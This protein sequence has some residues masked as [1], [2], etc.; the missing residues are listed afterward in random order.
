MRF[1]DLETNAS[2]EDVMYEIAT[3]HNLVPKKWMTIEEPTEAEIQ[4]T[5]SRMMTN[6]CYVRVVKEEHSE[7]LIGFIW[8]EIYEDH[9]MI[10]SLYV[11][12]AYRHQGIATQL[13]KDLEAWCLENEI[14]RI[15]TTV[16]YTNKE[17]LKLNTTLGYEAQMVHMVKNLEEN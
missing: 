11:K 7:T 3:L 1:E 12:K 10:I 8:A 6:K 16:H 13:K 2:T 15:K 14:Y 4:S 5:L 9:V 17:M